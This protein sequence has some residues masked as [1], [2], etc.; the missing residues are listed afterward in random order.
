MTVIEPRAKSP[1]LQM[2]KREKAVAIAPTALMLARPSL[3][4]PKPLLGHSVQDRSAL[5]KQPVGS[6]I[7]AISLTEPDT[8]ISAQVKEYD[9]KVAR[10]IAFASKNKAEQKQSLPKTTNVLRDMRRKENM[11]G[12]PAPNVIDNSHVGSVTVAGSRMRAN[13]SLE[14]QFDA[15]NFACGRGPR[16]GHGLGLSVGGSWFSRFTQWTPSQ[17]P[18]H[19]QV[20]TEVF[21]LSLSCCTVQIYSPSGLKRQAA[22]SLV[23][24]VRENGLVGS[25]ES[26]ADGGKR[27]GCTYRGMCSRLAGV[28]RLASRFKRL[29]EPACND[30]HLAEKVL[31][32][33]WSFQKKTARRAE[34]L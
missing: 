3:S 34:A 27:R 33:S 17:T 18:Y 21:V 23:F 26:D 14:R 11:V 19:L 20:V 15:P 31:E 6:P 8:A 10:A 30:T 12:Q 32:I 24:A 16:Q 4:P 25:Q 5:R 2:A 7:Y 22:V 13:E 9:E 28:A 1:S 29:A